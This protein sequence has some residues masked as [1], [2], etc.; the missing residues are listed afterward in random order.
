MENACHFKPKAKY[1]IK[2]DEEKGNIINQQ[3]H[4]RRLYKR[5]M[6]VISI[7]LKNPNK[8]SNIHYRSSPRKYMLHERKMVHCTIAMPNQYDQQ[9]ISTKHARIRTCTSALL[10]DAISSKYA[11]TSVK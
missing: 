9:S 1:P 3:E 4:K 6:L 10:Y 11:H 7:P 8:T 2:V 5:N